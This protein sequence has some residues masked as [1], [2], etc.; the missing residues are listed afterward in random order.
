MLGGVQA[1]PNLHLLQPALSERMDDGVASERPDS[2]GAP[3]SQTDLAQNVAQTRSDDDDDVLGIGAYQN[4]D[5]GD[6]D[7]SLLTSRLLALFERTGLPVPYRNDTSTRQPP[8][9][10]GD[11]QRLVKAAL[12]EGT[13]SGVA[14]LNTSEGAGVEGVDVDK[15]KALEGIANP[16]MQKVYAAAGG[17]PGGMPGAGGKMPGALGAGADESALEEID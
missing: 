15:Q 8:P 16:I 17:A 7:V 13:R 9:D 1:P 2:S 12:H 14:G 5:S 11:K 10:S 3:L 6:Y 4:A